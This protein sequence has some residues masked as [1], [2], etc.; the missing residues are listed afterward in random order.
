MRVLASVVDGS[1]DKCAQRIPIPRDSLVDDL[2]DTVEVSGEESE[3][4]GWVEGRKDGTCDDSQGNSAS[5]QEKG[6]LQFSPTADVARIANRENESKEC[7]GSDPQ[8]KLIG[9]PEELRCHDADEYSAEGPPGGNRQVVG[10]EVPR[11]RSHAG[12]FPV[13]DH[14]AR[15][16]A[17]TE[18]GEKDL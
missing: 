16:N 7:A 3:S 9:R 8:G 12:Q 14:A 1:V 11:V 6:S 10:R 5:Q 2:E 15:E 4:L 13:T 18:D 17:D